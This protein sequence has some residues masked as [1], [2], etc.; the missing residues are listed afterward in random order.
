VKRLEGQPHGLTLG[1]AQAQ[2]ELDADKNDDAL[3]HATALQV[4]AAER[5]ATSPEAQA[6]VLI[7]RAHL[8]QAASQQALDDLA[9]VKPE[10]V[11]SIQI[12]IQHQLVSGQAHGALE[13]P[14]EGFRQIDA[15]RAEAEKLGYVGLVFAARLAHAELAF[16][17]S[18][19][20]A[21]KERRE[22]ARDARARGF[23]RIAHLAETV[24]QR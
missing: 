17:L 13:D 15:A 24:D 12:R 21:A 6:W 19:P 23:K 14:D 18:K 8:A 1:L 3:A 11:E 20:D 4:A 22:L 2:A 7:A 16:T 9:H 10:S 5:G